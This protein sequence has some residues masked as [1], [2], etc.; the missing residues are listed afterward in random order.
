MMILGLQ[1][2]FDFGRR[3]QRFWTEKMVILGRFAIIA[4]SL[5]S[6]SFFLLLRHLLFL[7]LLLLLSRFHYLD[8][9]VY[10]FDEFRS[11]F[12][13]SFMICIDLHSMLLDSRE[14]KEG[15]G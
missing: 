7:L 13:M 11:R 6:S 9:F 10:G 8:E 2:G 4:S 5:A 3:K 15:R 14:G 1:S 12:R